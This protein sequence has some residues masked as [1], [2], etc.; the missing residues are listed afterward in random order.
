MIEDEDASHQ[1]F[2]SSEKLWISLKKK[3]KKT[4]YLGF[5]SIIGSP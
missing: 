4:L 5:R 2:N 3:K 1:T